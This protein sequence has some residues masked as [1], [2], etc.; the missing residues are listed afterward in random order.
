[1]KF[2]TNCAQHGCVAE[3]EGKKPPTLCPICKNPLL[4]GGVVVH[5][6]EPPPP[7][8]PPAPAPSPEAPPAS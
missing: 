5:A 2:T 8:P 7:P 4:E 3:G 6:P 1:M